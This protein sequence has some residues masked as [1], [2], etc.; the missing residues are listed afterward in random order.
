MEIGNTIVRHDLV[1]V[2]E[3]LVAAVVGWEAAPTAVW[4]ILVHSV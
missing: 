2:L 3:H 1:M 4:Q